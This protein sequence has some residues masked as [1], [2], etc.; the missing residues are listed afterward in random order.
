M[1]H[2][3]LT[4]I[5]ICIIPSILFF[6]GIEIVFRLIFEPNRLIYHFDSHS[7]NYYWLKTDNIPRVVNKHTQTDFLIQARKC[8]DEIK[9]NADNTFKIVILGASSAIGYPYDPCLAFSNFLRILLSHSFPKK[10]F[11][12]LNMAVFAQTY[13]FALKAA[14]DSM[15]LKP[16]MIIVYAG[17]NER[18]AHNLI[19]VHHQLKRS[20]IKHAIETV[21]SFIEQYSVAYQWVLD[22]KDIYS[23]KKEIQIPE[24]FN[25]NN[26]LDLV[27]SHYINTTEQ[28]IKSAKNNNVRLFFSTLLRNLKDYPPHYYEG[29]IDDSFPPL[30]IHT[31]NTFNEYQKSEPANIYRLARWYDKNN[32]ELKANQYYIKAS[33]YAHNVGR[34]H[35]RLQNFIRKIHIT[36]PYANCVDTEKYIQKRKSITTIGKNEIIDWVH[37]RVET[38]YEI[39]LSLFS[40]I[41]KVFN[42]NVRNNLEKRNNVLDFNAA[43]KLTHTEYE[44]LQANG[45]VEGGFVNLQ[46]SGCYAAKQLFLEGLQKKPHE[47]IKVK[48]LIGLSII[49]LKTNNKNYFSNII[50][51]LKQFSKESLINNLFDYR[52]YD[53]VNKIYSLL[54][55]TQEY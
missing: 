21:S 52:F 10:R 23:P 7:N 9:G 34:I 55:I 22:Q 41:R 44:K 26:H 15:L 12:I 16:D 1:K 17:H 36:Y 2:H 8:V 43:L 54:D 28:I 37:P 20:K 25:P 29:T 38:N 13:R 6:V 32:N 3:K 48:S 14:F 40:E 42:K 33:D 51:Q 46:T 5:L 31:Y 24:G 18:Y 39:A 47:E 11:V 19:Q 30:S 49:A 53:Q 4:I 27:C 35:S 45:L 50:E